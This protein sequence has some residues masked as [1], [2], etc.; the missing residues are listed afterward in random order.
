[1]RY[2]V[3]DVEHLVE[4]MRSDETL[5]TGTNGAARSKDPE[6]RLALRDVAAAIEARRDNW[7]PDD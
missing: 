7:P 5:L 3:A 2:T 6:T 4:R 1:V